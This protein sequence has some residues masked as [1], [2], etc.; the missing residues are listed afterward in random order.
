MTK[1]LRT[2]HVAARLGISAEMVRKLIRG[3]MLKAVKWGK[4][5]WRV[6]VEDLEAFIQWAKNAGYLRDL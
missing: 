6:S 1:Y 3:R 4:R 2:R 5:E